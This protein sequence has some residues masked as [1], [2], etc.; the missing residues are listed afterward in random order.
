MLFRSV[1]MTYEGEG[2]TAYG[3]SNACVQ[4]AV[5]HYLLTGEAPA[6][7]TVC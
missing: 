1:L 6:D 3:R 2:H 7:G 4:D 5:D